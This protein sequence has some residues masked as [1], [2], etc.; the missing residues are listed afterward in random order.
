[1]LSFRDP[2][3]M[4]ALYTFVELTEDDDLAVAIMK[5]LDAI[6]DEYV[7]SNEAYKEIERQVARQN[8]EALVRSKRWG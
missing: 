5:R 8:A 1:M 7:Q 6:A 2:A 4:E 3:A